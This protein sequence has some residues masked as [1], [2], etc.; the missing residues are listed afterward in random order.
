METPTF[1][2]EALGLLRDVGIDNGRLQVG[3]AE[4]L[5]NR[6]FDLRSMIHFDQK[7]YGRDVTLVGDF[8]PMTGKKHAAAFS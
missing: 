6:S 5:R 3:Q 1:S 8:L 7:T 4:D 2:P